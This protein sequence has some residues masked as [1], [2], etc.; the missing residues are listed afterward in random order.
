MVA[1]IELHTF[2]SLNKAFL[3]QYR[4]S[5]NGADIAV[6]YIDEKTFQHKKMEPLNE[7]DVQTSFNDKNIIFFNEATALEEYFRNLNFKNTNLL[8][9]SCLLYTSRCV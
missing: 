1:C 8:L 2:S 4:D 6:V 3:D 9:M 5:M 7:L